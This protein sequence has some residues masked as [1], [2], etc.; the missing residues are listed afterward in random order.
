MTNGKIS[1]GEFSVIF[2]VSSISFLGSL[3]SASLGDNYVDAAIA[4]A[5]SALVNLLLLIPVI[6][7][8][9]E[10]RLLSESKFILWAY[11]L[12]FIYSA[13]T[14]ISSLVHMM[15]NTVF[16]GLNAYIFALFFAGCAFYCARLGPETAS[17]CS[18]IAVGV[19]AVC[20]GLMLIASVKHIEF[21]NLRVP[22]YGGF[23]DFT[24][25]FWDF[26]GRMMF[27]PQYVFLLDNMEKDERI[28]LKIS[29]SVL[30]AGL[31]ISAAVII[32]LLCLGCFAGTQEFPVFTLASF[33]EISPLQRLDIFLGI[34]LLTTSLIKLSVTFIAIAKCCSSLMPSNPGGVSLVIVLV[35][36][37][38]SALVADNP[39]LISKFCLPAV[40]A[41]TGI[42]LGCAVPQF[43]ISSE[44]K[45]GRKNADETS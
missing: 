31:F 1:G 27:L 30:A 28:G 17:R 39:M 26:F 3:S 10:G 41:A 20:S 13:V 15:H 19:L 23:L 8:K 7:A 43:R 36:A 6:R 16:P 11:L 29:V 24:D 37:L 35:T 38:L 44:R 22:F 21:G 33:L 14:D 18:Q 2:F 9:G 40:L 25:S 12:F 5:L 45:A 34:S 32:T 42:L 4:A